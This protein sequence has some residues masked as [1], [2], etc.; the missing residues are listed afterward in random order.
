MQKNTLIY[1]MKNRDLAFYWFSMMASAMATT[2]D[3]GHMCCMMAS[4]MATT[5]DVGHMLY[6]GQCYGHH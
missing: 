4:A 1:P 6:D 3:V 2:S 5:S